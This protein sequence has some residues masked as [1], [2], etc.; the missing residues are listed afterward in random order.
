[1]QKVLAGRVA[2]KPTDCISLSSVNSTQIIDGRAIIYKAGGKVY[3]NE[4]RSGAETLRDDDILLTQT[5]GSQL[6]SIDSVKLLDRGARFQRGFVTL[7]KFVPYSL[8]KVAG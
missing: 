3:V 4:P 5:F 7:G 6:C 1:M 8:V 2:G